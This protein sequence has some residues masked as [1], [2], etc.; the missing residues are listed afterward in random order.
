[1]RF[2]FLMVTGLLAPSVALADPICETVEDEAVTEE[3]TRLA[4]AYPMEQGHTVFADSVRIVL[5]C[6]DFFIYP[7]EYH[8]GVLGGVPYVF[9]AYD[10]TLLWHHYAL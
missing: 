6:R 2:I 10:G 8:E 4:E 9:F 1:M 5:Y 7:N 3:A